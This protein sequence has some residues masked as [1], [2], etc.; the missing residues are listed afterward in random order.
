MDNTITE[1]TDNSLG[2]IVD[3]PVATALLG[4]LI[5]YYGVKVDKDLIKDDIYFGEDELR[6][7][8]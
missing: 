4:H 1:K 3:G 5:M 8:L 2:I 6:K 7:M